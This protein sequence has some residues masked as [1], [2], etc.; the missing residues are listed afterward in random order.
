MQGYRGYK[1]L[2]DFASII[3]FYNLFNLV[4]SCNCYMLDVGFS[5]IITLVC[6]GPLTLI[7]MY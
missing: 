4:S 3:T 5:K 1:R 7:I 6:F 2:C